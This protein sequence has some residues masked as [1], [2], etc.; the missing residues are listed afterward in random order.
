[1]SNSETFVCL[2]DI[3]EEFGYTTYRRAAAHARSGIFPIK[4]FKVASVI[5]MVREVAR[6]YFLDTTLESARELVASLEAEQ[7]IREL[8]DYEEAVKKL[9]P[10]LR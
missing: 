10:Y 8:R 4:I 2:H 7:I 1:M 5:F 6:I 9:P 3:W